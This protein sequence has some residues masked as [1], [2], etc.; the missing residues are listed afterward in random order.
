ME[1]INGLA[2][3][4]NFLTDEE[5]DDLLE[6]IY[7]HK[8]DSRLSRRVQHYGHLYTYNHV[9]NNDAP[10]V[11]PIPKWILKLFKKLVSNDIAPD[12]DI[13]K[14]QVIINEYKPGQ[15]IGRHIDDPIKFG[16]WVISVS[17]NSGCE[18]F[19]ANKK[20]NKVCK[21][22]VARCSVYRMKKDA[23]YLWTHQISP[24]KKDIVDGITI[25]RETRISIT[26]REVS[27]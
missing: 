15:G 22:Y 4:E 26:F 8:W 13:D 11:E 17:L 23:R 18:V 20:T 3:Y 25:N 14:L 1:T 2:Y 16:K 24:K 21:I 19:F 27:A 6:K 7:A 12:I 9:D 10:V 5:E